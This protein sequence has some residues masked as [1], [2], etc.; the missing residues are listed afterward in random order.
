MIIANSQQ[1]IS[2][3]LLPRVKNVGIKISGGADSAIVAYMLA[4]YIA[5][6][7]PDVTIIPITINFNGRAYQEEFSKKVIAFIE[8]EFNIKF[9][10]HKIGFCPSVEAFD[11]YQKQF[12]YNITSNKEID[13][14]YYGVTK[15]PSDNVLETFPDSKKIGPKDDRTPLADNK[16]RPTMD[17]YWWGFTPLV[18]IDK[19]GV[20]ELY[21]HFGLMDTLFPLT[22]SCEAWTTDFTKHCEECWWCH[23]RHW[24][25]GRYV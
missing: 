12:M 14:L 6:E 18:N 25:F 22:R 17:R 21:E 7:R 10:E 15:N 16:K 24:G 1:N 11:D 5:E 3:Y 20:R 9:G 23:E 19:Q 4:K 2:I 13:S 8:K